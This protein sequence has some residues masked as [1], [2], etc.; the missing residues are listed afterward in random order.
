MK[1]A[2]IF[3]RDDHVLST[4]RR[5][6]LFTRLESKPLLIPI[7]VLSCLYHKRCHH[8]VAAKQVKHEKSQ[9]ISPSS[10]Q[11]FKMDHAF[12]KSI[13]A[14]FSIAVLCYC[15]SRK[16]CVIGS[17][18]TIIIFSVVRIYGCVFVLPI[19]VETAKHDQFNSI[20]HVNYRPLAS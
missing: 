4:R 19:F 14:I 15:A 13:S 5:N 7:Y 1:L 6:D 18:H 10:H 8:P 9:I 12:R 2:L 20:L 3:T 17:F 16:R 11:I